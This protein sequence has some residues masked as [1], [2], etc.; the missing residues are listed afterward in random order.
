M[1]T[2]EKPLFR[3][4]ALRPR[5][6]AFTV[7]PALASAR[8]KLGHW[9]KLLGSKQADALKETELLGDFLADAFV[10]LLRYTGPAA[11]PERYTMK[12]VATVEAD[13]KLA[14][15]ALGHSST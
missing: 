9:S 1:P 4:E 8:T 11:N 10:E 5:L 3:S 14:D 15:A 2:A 13:G 6:S 7:P 12:R